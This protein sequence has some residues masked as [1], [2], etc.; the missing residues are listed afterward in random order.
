MP[1]RREFLKQSALLTA[2]AALANNS[3]ALN[4]LSKPKVIILG[5]GFAGLAAGKM[6]IENGYDVTILEA[7]NRT[8]GRVFSYDIDDGVDNGVDN[9]SSPGLASDRE[10]CFA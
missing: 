8:G 5:A 6:L 10:E 9:G 4:L 3:F 2:G 1:T 7:R